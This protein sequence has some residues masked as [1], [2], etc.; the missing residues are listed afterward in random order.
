MSHVATIIRAELADVKDRLA[1]LELPLD[2]LAE[3]VAI[4]YNAAAEATPFHAANAAGTL[5]YQWGT[6]ALRDRLVDENWRPDRPEG[7]EAIINEQTGIRVAFCNVNV[8]CKERPEPQPRSKKGA[9]AER[10]FSS[11]SL[12]ASLP[13]YYKEQQTVGDTFYL[14]LDP[15]GRAELSKPIVKNGAFK[16][17]VERIWLPAEGFDIPGGG[18]VGQF[19]DGDAISELEPKISRK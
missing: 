7:I 18:V 3:I 8:A 12:F 13:T 10:A 17:F 11:N 5:S 2:M 19:D 16:G 14:M 15:D 4:A 9:G 1:E 6:W